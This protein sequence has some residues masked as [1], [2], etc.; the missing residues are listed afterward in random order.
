MKM[1]LEFDSMDELRAF[2]RDL[3]RGKLEEEARQKVQK[4]KSETTQRGL[5]KNQKAILGYVQDAGRIVLSSEIAE[6]LGIHPSA[7][8]GCLSKLRDRG[9]V[10]SPRRGQWTVGEG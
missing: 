3:V 6:N 4:E 8:S 2:A 5:G 7:V 9:L 1:H 10:A